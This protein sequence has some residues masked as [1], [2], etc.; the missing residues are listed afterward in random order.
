F[1][2]QH[3]EAFLARAPYSEAA[4]QLVFMAFLHR[5][6]NGGG[7]IDREY[8]VGSGRID[9]CIRWPHPLGTERFA[10]ELKVWRDRR[11]DPLA[12]GLTQLASYLDRLALDSGTLILFDG[13]SQAVP[14]PERC[15][16]QCVRHGGHTITVLRL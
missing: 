10:I 7:M 1:W 8:A 5:I 2:V 13:R 15:S 14:L 9:L 12:A 3:A 16:T 6:V 11:P 4:A